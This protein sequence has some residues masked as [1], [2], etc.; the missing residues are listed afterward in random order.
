M[1]HL[2]PDQLEKKSGLE[3]QCAFATGIILG[4]EN[5]TLL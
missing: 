3:Y 4:T 1:I 5:P 2:L